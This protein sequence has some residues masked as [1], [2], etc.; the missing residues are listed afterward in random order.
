MSPKRLAVY[1]AILLTLT[2][3]L[4]RI[5][6]AQESEVIAGGEIE[7][8]RHCATCHGVDGKGKGYMAKSLTV[9]PSD[10]TQLARKNGNKF[11]FWHAYRTID[12]REEV[13]GH[14]TRE[15]PVW[16]SRFKVEAGGS[17]PASRAT[18]AGRILGLVFYLEHT[19]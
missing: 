6:P 18:V 9:E 13:R 8:Q 4:S 11:P 19:L 16:G 2:W 1:I 14:G 3:P 17:D 12:G 7:Y 10:L 15:M 5:A